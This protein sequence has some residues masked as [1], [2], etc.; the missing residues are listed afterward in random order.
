MYKHLR[1]I[2]NKGLLG[3]IIAAKSFRTSPRNTLASRNQLIKNYT[4]AKDSIEVTCANNS[5]NT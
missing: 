5:K 3:N 4:A 2:A 1:Y